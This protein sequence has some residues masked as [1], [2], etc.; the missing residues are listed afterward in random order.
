MNPIGGE[1]ARYAAFMVAAQRPVKGEALWL[2]PALA[3]ALLRLFTIE[4]VV[5]V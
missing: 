3:S 5:G 2:E 4:G 1:Q